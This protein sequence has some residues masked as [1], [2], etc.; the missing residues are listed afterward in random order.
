MTRIA[1]PQ[2]AR[3]KR[4][5]KLRRRRQRD[6]Q[7]LTVIDGTREIGRAID[8]GIE[9]VELFI[10]PEQLTSTGTELLEQIDP[11]SPPRFEVSSAL[12]EKMAFGDRAEGLVAVAVVR[13]CGLTD[14]QIESS[15]AVTVVEGVEK[16]GNL[17]AILRTA[18]AAGI[19]GVIVADGRTDL[20]NP[21]VIRA[22]LATVFS[23]PICSATAPET[24]AWL[25]TTQRKMFAARVDAT[26]DY[27]AVDLRG[28]SALILG[29]EADG[30]TSLWNEDDVTAVRVPMC[31]AAESLNVSATAAVLFYEALRQRSA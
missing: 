26:L 27:T 29:S 17:G 7:S 6:R 22:S 25:R 16:P 3:I 15:A 9:I 28:P 2:N 12:F 23:L 4:V 10:C 30:L 13:E 8:C 5:V 21:A 1:S 18:D 24:L 11:D 20:Y 31:G 19:A 14:F